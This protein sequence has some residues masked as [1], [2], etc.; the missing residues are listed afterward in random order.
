MA[1][2]ESGASANDHCRAMTSALCRENGVPPRSATHLANSMD[3]YPRRFRDAKAAVATI[4]ELYERTT[5]RLR[6]AFSAYTKGQDFA[7]RVRGYYPFLRLTSDSPPG[8]DPRSAYGFIA[9]AGVYATTVTRPD[10]FGR[11]LEEQIALLLKTTGG[12][13]EGGESATPI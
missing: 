9:D 3:S 10:I 4:S 2:R 8:I 13:G 11:Y 1:H 6:E 5:T 7:Q 12:D